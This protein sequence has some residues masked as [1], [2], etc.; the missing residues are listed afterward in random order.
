MTL[1][2]NFFGIDIGKLNFVTSLYGTKST[3]EYENSGEGIRKFIEKNYAKL[4]NSLCVLETTGGYE[5]ELLYTLIDKGIK[6]HRADTRKVRNF[7]RSFGQNAKT[8]SL[9]AK[10]LALYAHD[11]Q[12]K[13][14]LFEPQSKEQLYLFKLV[15]R[16]DDLTQILVAEKNRL[17]APGSDLI[18]D[19]IENIITLF[20]EEIDT[21]RQEIQS[22]IDKDSLLKK[23]QEVLITIPGI[24]PIISTELLV[25][26]PE[27]G[28]MCRRK[29]ASLTGVAPQSNES[30]KFIGYRKTGKGRHKVKQKLFLAA[31]SARNSKT[32]LK[33]FYER[34]ILKGKKKMVA[35]TALMRKIIVIANAR[36]AEFLNSVV[37]SKKLA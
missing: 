30:G 8:D 28:T 1:Y 35:M 5:L 12:D 25:L 14:S 9:D 22:I 16:T 4:Q 36:I 11:R 26:L 21:L 19:S 33:A 20:E 2:Q 37:I 7:A 23:K 6:V 32:D 18:K 34:L 27:L 10:I 17:Q 29:I 15:Q 31:M 24:G 3:I 13:L